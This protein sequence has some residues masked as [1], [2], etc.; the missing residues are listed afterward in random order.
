MSDDKLHP[1]VREF[2]AFMN[3]HPK[4]VEEVRKSGR[5][6]QEYYEK[7]VL[8]GEDDSFWEKY[9]KQNGNGKSRSKGGGQKELLNQ[10]V[11]LSESID[12]DKVQ[13]QVGNLNSAITTVQELLGQ[14]QSDKPQ[15]TF[16]RPYHQDNWF[17]D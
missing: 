2:K 3:R 6:W 13:S 17:K 1:S 5:S 16:R 14:F 4:L 15:Q 8:L 7:W 10:L 12:L 11:K 9:K